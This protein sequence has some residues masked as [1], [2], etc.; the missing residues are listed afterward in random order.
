V[1]SCVLVDGGG[2][3]EARDRMCATHG[4][5]AIMIELAGHV[6]NA[7]AF[8]DRRETV[9]RILA[10]LFYSLSAVAPGAAVSSAFSS[11]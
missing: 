10:D 9:V 4:H 5:E 11:R 8:D 7:T 6:E 1:T 2:Q 3:D